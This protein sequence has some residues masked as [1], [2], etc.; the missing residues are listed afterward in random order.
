VQEANRRAM[1]SAR[2]RMMDVVES[3][4]DG[5]V[6]YDRHRRV[7][8]FNRRWRELV[9]LEHAEPEGMTLNEVL[10]NAVQHVDLRDFGSREEWIRRRLELGLGDNESFV[11][12][13]KD[14][15]WIDVRQFP[16]HDGS[17]VATHTDVTERDA[18]RDVGVHGHATA[19]DVRELPPTVVQ[20]QARQLSE[21]AV[22]VTVPE[23]DVEIAVTVDITERDAA[24]RVVVDR[25][26]C[27]R[28]VLEAARTVVQEQAVLPR[29]RAGRLHRLLAQPQPARRPPRPVDGQF[30]R[31]D[32]G[33]G[34]RQ[35]R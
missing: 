27:L 11:V 25:H 21:R 20:V 28:C 1:D 30:L 8:V 14:G 24:R 7:Q 16:T 9:G 33:H 35:D 4:S 6:L 3:M 2:R 34:L 26:E 19:R 15:R 10:E 31:P 12:H 22:V 23:H 5:F 17:L 13:L 32:R 29:D 18:L